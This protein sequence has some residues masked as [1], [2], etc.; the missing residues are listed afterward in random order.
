MICAYTLQAILSSPVHA[1]DDLLDSFRANIE[2]IFQR[3]IVLKDRRQTVSVRLDNAL[4]ECF[5]SLSPTSRDEELEDVIYF[6]LDIY[7]F[8]G[9]PVASAEVD[10]DQAVIDLRST[11]EDYTAKSQGRVGKIEDAHLFLVL[12]KNVQAIPWESI[13]SLRGRSVSRIPSLDFLLDR[14]ELAKGRNHE[15]SRTATPGAIAVDPRS[16]F[17]VLNPS[18]DLKNTEARF[19]GMLQDMKKLGWEG[20]VGRPPSEQQLCDAFTRKDLVLYACK[21]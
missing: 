4:V 12:D 21:F 9:I 16:V 2:R 17:Y 15:Q 7:Q 3:S 6:I 19:I 5:A 8:H 11:L 14:L 20:V 13:P 1:P 10:I 18:G